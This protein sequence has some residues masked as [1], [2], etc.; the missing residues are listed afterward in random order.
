MRL[1]DRRKYQ[2]IEEVDQIV[3]LAKLI[4][5]KDTEYLCADLR[6]RLGE[7][8][9]L[10]DKAYVRVSCYDDLKDVERYGEDGGR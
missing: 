8:K 7:L 10:V 9:E 1:I 5:M 4:E 3:Q 6:I 2:I